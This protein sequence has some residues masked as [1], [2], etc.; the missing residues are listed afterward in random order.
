MSLLDEFCFYAGLW[1]ETTTDAE[2]YFERCTIYSAKGLPYNHVVDLWILARH[3]AKFERSKKGKTRSVCVCV[4]CVRACVRVRA[5][6]LVGTAGPGVRV[7]VHPVLLVPEQ[8][9]A[10]A[11]RQ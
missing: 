2:F 4:L 5:R 8:A 3:R 9:G 11:D 10:P 1:S 7:Q 6:C